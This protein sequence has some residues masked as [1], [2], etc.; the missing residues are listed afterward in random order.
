MDRNTMTVSWAVIEFWAISAHL[1]IKCSDKFY[2]INHFFLIQPFNSRYKY[3]YIIT[4]LTV[5]FNL[6]LKNN[7]KYNTL[8]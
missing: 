1:R 8:F 6:Y 4:L 7:F 5:F 3:K 2:L